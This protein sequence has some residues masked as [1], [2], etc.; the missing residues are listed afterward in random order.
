MISIL[1]VAISLKVFALSTSTMTLAFFAVIAIRPF[2]G[3]R[4]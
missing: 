1:G 2:L 4:K 3:G